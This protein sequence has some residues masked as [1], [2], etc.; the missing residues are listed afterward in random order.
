MKNKNKFNFTFFS[1][2]TVDKQF[3][4]IQKELN[5]SMDYKVL[6][7]EFHKI[8]HNRVLSTLI[9][10]SKSEE[11]TI[12]RITKPWKK[13]DFNN[14]NSYSY[15]PNPQEIGR[16]HRKGFP[17]FYGSIDPF[18][19]FSEMKDSIKINDKFYMSRWKLKFKSDTNVHSL[20]INSST[21]NS[22]HVLNSVIK[23]PYVGLKNMVK[24]IPNEFKEGYIY[25]I[26][27]MGDL[28]TTKGI[29]NYHI[30]SAYC[31]EI[32]Y[33]AKSKGINIPILLYPSVEN[34]LN[35]I[36]WAI[37]PTIVDSEEMKIQDV[38]ELSLKENNSKNKKGDVSVLIHKKGILDHNSSINWEI[39]HFT[40]FK[41]S[42]DKLN[43]RTYNNQIIK[44][45]TASKLKV[46]DTEFTIK[47]LIENNIN[48]KEIQE[49]IPE[50]TSNSQE[51]SAL[52]LEK[53]T[54][55]WSMVLQFEHG[56]EIETKIGKSCIN[57]IQIPIS[58]T[59]AFKIEK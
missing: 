28:F 57:L 12:F 32:L 27:K 59:R 29:S 48:R 35:S 45:K 37:H 43:I 58:W 6:I 34:S 26:E 50:M 15:N 11:F 2:E 24:N 19:A 9:Y 14:P 31:H 51:D 47:E 17:V 46:N 10:D 5:P 44:G 55:S 18:T 30:T 33:E 38:F 21:K 22:E 23:R 56:N 42:Y 41:I 25:A 52:D 49:K 16:A 3:D 4:Q 40:K 53:E 39:P 54:F 7:K 13:F 1:K 36:N 8:L 20:I